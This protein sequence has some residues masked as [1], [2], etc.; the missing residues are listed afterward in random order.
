MQS[1]T[2][3]KLGIHLSLLG[4]LLFSQNCSDGFEVQNFAS[5]DSLAE[6]SPPPSPNPVGCSAD[7]SSVECGGVSPQPQ[8]S[9]QG[10]TDLEALINSSVYSDSRIV[11]VSSSLGNDSTGQVYR[12]DSSQL[13]GRPLDPSGSIAPFSSL[14]AAWAQIRNGSADVMLLRRGDTWTSSLITNKAGPSASARIIV[15]A[16][17][18]LAAERPRVGYLFPGALTTAGNQILAHYVSVFPSNTEVATRG[19]ATRFEGVMF[20]GPATSVSPVLV[21]ALS[22]GTDVTNCSFSRVRLF[23]AAE[24]GRGNMRFWDNVMWHPAGY[25]GAGGFEHN[26]YFQF[27]V[28]DIDSRRNISAQ[29]PGVGFRQRGLGTIE[30]N[31]VLGSRLATYDIGTNTYYGDGDPANRGTFLNMRFNLALHTPG[32]YALYD[33]KNAVIEQNI[34][35]A[36][37]YLTYFQNT[38]AVGNPLPLTNV[39][40]QDNIFYGSYLVQAAGHGGSVTGPYLIRRNDF[41]RPSGGSLVM[42]QSND[43]VYEN[44]NRFWSNSQLEYWFSGYTSNYASY[45]PSRGNNTRVLYPDP[46]RDL[47][48][49]CLAFF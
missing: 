27:D 22:G 31:L 21:F 11:Y 8:P 38:A 14:Q 29:S 37:Q 10:W 48:T 44:N 45:V 35:L 6:S 33:I 20:T 23:S 39:I 15:A 24:T 32:A 30:A 12:P 28:G 7:S 25:V 17:G 36:D 4:T 40:L 43:F 18:S 34:F 49:Y 1:K 5:L 13:G 46:N 19:F 3:K 16:Y 9:L 42:A 47:I 2:V 26:N 41:Q